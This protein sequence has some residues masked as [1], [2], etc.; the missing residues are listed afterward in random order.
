MVVAAERVLAEHGVAGLTTNRIAEVAGVSIG[1]LYQYFPN[2]EAIA[3]AL[4]DRYVAKFIGTAMKLIAE[5]A[6]A[7]PVAIVNAIGVAVTQLFRE[8]QPVHR[9]LR[10]LRAVAGKLEPLDRALDTLVDVVGAYLRTRP[11][12]DLDPQV[13][14]FTIVHT[15]DGTINAFAVRQQSI[16]PPLEDPE[17]VGRELARMLAAYLSSSRRA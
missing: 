11:E 4:I 1:S 15:V 17:T 8:H 10:D 14:A 2:K 5:N 7:E 3:A 13:A 6:N 12:L 9:H 16:Q